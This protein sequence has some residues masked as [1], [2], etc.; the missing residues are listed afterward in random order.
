[1]FKEM[2]NV[3]KICSY[4]FKQE[5]FILQFLILKQIIHNDTIK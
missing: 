1:M 5:M 3:F 4:I 2:Y